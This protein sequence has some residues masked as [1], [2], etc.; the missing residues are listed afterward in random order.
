MSLDDGN[1]GVNDAETRDA[2]S[3]LDA[4]DTRPLT[5]DDGGSDVLR[6]ATHEAVTDIAASDAEGL[7]QR[8]VI[9]VAQIFDH[10]RSHAKVI[11]FLGQAEGKLRG[12]AALALKENGIPAAI[13]NMA[14]EMNRQGGGMT[15]DYRPY[16]TEI[17]RLVVE[18]YKL[19]AE[20][21]EP[22]VEKKA[23]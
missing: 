19:L 9:A 4:D 5:A 3:V 8:V 17:C 10:C 12:A 2:A 7:R 22:D 18:H 23:G 15:L 21:G 20:D 6:K 16:V 14:V 11:F 1:N 13:T